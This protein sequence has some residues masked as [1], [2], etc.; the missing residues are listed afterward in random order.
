MEGK[1]IP[2]RIKVHIKCGIIPGVI[3][4]LPSGVIP[5]FFLWITQCLDDV[6]AA[7]AEFNHFVRLAACTK[8]WSASRGRL[9]QPAVT[10]HNNATM[11]RGCFMR[12]GFAE[13]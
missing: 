5:L 6:L 10:R 7:H 9:T 4:L 8:R 12:K 11:I 1:N 13:R 2:R 3:S